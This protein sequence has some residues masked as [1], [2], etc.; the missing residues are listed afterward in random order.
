[1][2]V[3]DQLPDRDH[4]RL[5]Q[6]SNS[7]S[8]TQ[9]QNIHVS[10]HHVD[11]APPYLALSYAWDAPTRTCSVQSNLGSLLVT[12]NLE[13][14]L[15]ELA[16]LMPLRKCSHLWID[17]I[18]INQANKP[19]KARQVSQMRHI[20]QK[21]AIVIVWIGESDSNTRLDFKSLEVLVDA[22]T[23]QRSQDGKLNSQIRQDPWSEQDFGSGSRFE[24]L[25]AAIERLMSRPYFCRMWTMQEVLVATDCIVL[26]GPNMMSY[27]TFTTAMVGIDLAGYSLYYTYPRKQVMSLALFKLTNDSLGETTQ[28]DLMECLTAFRGLKTSDPRDQVYAMLGLGVPTGFEECTVDYS[29]TVEATYSKFTKQMITAYDNLE[30]LSLVTPYKLSKSDMLLPSWVPDF[31]EDDWYTPLSSVRRESTLTRRLSQ[32]ASSVDAAIYTTANPDVLALRGYKV[33]VVTDCTDVISYIRNRFAGEA[34]HSVDHLELYR[35]FQDFVGLQTS[36]E[37]VHTSQSMSDAFLQ[38][39]S[40]DSY[41]SFIADLDEDD[42]S[43]RLP[44]CARWF[45]EAR[46]NMDERTNLWRGIWD[47]HG[48]AQVPELLYKEARSYH[49]EIM[50]GRNLLITEKGYLGLG[51]TDIRAGDT[52]CLLLGGD[53]PYLVREAS[54]DHSTFLGECYL[55][56]LD[57][58]EMLEDLDESQFGDFKFI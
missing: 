12:K 53:I 47:S 15:G 22:W 4:I 1:M 33:D 21:A 52:I 51:S 23:S 24:R 34:Q 8:F 54:G 31:T 3:Y 20:F 7:P 6:L 41:P 45:R 40:A 43:I 35:L 39:L 29:M 2:A 32:S 36:Q 14:A 28:V 49:S 44:H 57:A 16:R 38:T 37:Y 25:S 5:A 50:A 55:H 17:A 42:I 46:P 9:E 26:C 19:E 58:V 56:G 27:Q 11:H 10:T 18:C 13:L 30:I 48:N